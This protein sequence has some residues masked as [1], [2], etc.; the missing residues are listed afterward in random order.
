MCGL[1]GLWWKW[2]STVFAVEMVYNWQLFKSVV[3][4]FFFLKLLTLLII[5]MSDTCLFKIFKSINTPIRSAHRTWYLLFG[6]NLMLNPSLKTLVME[7][8]AASKLAEG[9]VFRNFHLFVTYAALFS[10][11]KSHLRNWFS[12]IRRWGWQHLLTAASNCT[13]WSLSSKDATPSLIK[14]E[15]CLLILVSYISML[16]S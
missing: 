15:P 3:A 12:I 10:W 8:P 9:Q 4:L 2:R 14:F 11:L 5:L 7:I 16:L 6:W 1:S 13:P